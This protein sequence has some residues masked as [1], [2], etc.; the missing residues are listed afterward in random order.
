MIKKLQAGD[1]SI[2]ASGWNEMRAFIQ[3]YSFPQDT[4][5]SPPRNPA[6]IYV[7]NVTGAALPALSIV[8]ISTPIYTRSGDTFKNKGV[9]YGVEMNG[10]A[11]SSDSDNI[12]VIQEAIRP[13]CIGR[14]ICSGA[15]PCIIHK[16]EN[17]T[18]KYAKPVTSQTVYME[19]TDDIT[20]YRVLWI[21]TGT[22]NKEAFIICDASGT[23]EPEYF[24]INPGNDGTQTQANDPTVYTKGSLHYIR[25][26]TSYNAWIPYSQ[27]EATPSTAPQIR[28]NGVK[29]VV[30]QC[31][32][33]NSAAEY[34]MPYF[35]P[36]SNIGVPPDI[37][38]YNQGF[39][40]TKRCGVL[41]GEHEFTNGAFDYLVTGLN[42]SAGTVASGSGTFIYQPQFIEIVQVD[43]STGGGNNPTADIF[44]QTWNVGVPSPSDGLS[45]A[46]YPD[47]YPYDVITVLVDCEAQLCLAIDYS[48][49]FPV[50]DTVVSYNNP[51][52]RGWEATTTPQALA[53][54][55]LTI[56]IKVKT[57]AIT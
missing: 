54:I 35:T 56:Y 8:K 57:G 27:N 47:I 1:N 52:G 21:A 26:D 20:N 11:P 33:P 38:T 7:K 18:Y 41:M 15:T 31:D 28:P 13:G 10:A 40:G 42:G 9:E 17:K 24:L 22:G 55:G 53:D 19:G 50:N 44:G 3:D 43:G 32:A 46:S 34:K 5:K 12:A 2:P 23:P 4:F 49:D 16:A 37:S 29:L 6:Y 39:N 48:R 14:A 30:C 51:G 36:E 25:Y 45:R